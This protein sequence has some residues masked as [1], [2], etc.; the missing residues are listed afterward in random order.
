LAAKRLQLPQRLSP[1]QHD[2]EFQF[3]KLI[4]RFFKEIG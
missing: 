2:L 3:S 1:H 4:Q